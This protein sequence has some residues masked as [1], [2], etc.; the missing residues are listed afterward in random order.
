MRLDSVW[1][2][3]S[4]SLNP[5]F[6]VFDVADIYSYT[7]LHESYVFEPVKAIPGVPSRIFVDKSEFDHLLLEHKIEYKR[8]TPLCH[9][10]TKAI[11]W[12]L[13]NVSRYPVNQSNARVVIPI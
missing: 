13:S 1:N 9:R 3:P 12:L 11:A 10:T 6:F 4:S 2:M 5:S 7:D 8:S